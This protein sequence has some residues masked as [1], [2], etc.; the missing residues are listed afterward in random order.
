MAHT[1]KESRKVK[2]NVNE[3]EKLMPWSRSLLLT[4]VALH[5]ILCEYVY[6][7]QYH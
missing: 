3:H 5:M 1:S 4:L 7:F 6:M 2:L